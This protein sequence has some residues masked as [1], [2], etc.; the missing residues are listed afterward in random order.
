MSCLTAALIS[1]AFITEIHGLAPAALDPV[2]NTPVSSNSSTLQ[3]LNLS[4]TPNDTDLVNANSGVIRCMGRDFGYNLNKTSCDEVWKKI[5][6]DY[7][8]LSF[9]VRRV[10]TFERPLPYRYLSGEISPVY[11]SSITPFAA[12]S[13]HADDGLCAIDVDTM[14]NFDSDTATNHDIST[15]AKSVLNKCVFED[16]TRK[17]GYESPGG[18]LP[19][20][21]PYQALLTFQNREI[22]LHS[23]TSSKLTL[24]RASR[25]A[26]WTHCQSLLL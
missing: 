13:S 1:L 18:I 23:L 4:N 19:G 26:C 20:V 3:L 16:R 7:E 22:Y 10:G 17:T 6:T 2:I 8:I 21:G 5:P 12:N 25:Q 15:A 14:N 24:H 9:G 11:F